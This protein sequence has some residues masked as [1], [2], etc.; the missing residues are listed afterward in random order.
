[1][2][3]M[4]NLKKTTTEKGETLRYVSESN[5]DNSAVAKRLVN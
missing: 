2:P 5:S 3:F 4:D 1:M